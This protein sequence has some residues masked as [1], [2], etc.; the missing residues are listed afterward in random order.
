MFDRFTAKPPAY[1]E[2]MLQK[3]RSE[4]FKF[5]QDLEGM[6]N[7]FFREI[8]DLHLDAISL[9]VCSEDLPDDL[10]MSAQNR[11]KTLMAS[12][13]TAAVLQHTI[14]QTL[15]VCADYITQIDSL[16]SVTLP[17]WKVAFQ[18]GNP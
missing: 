8:T 5:V 15:L 4:L 10:Q 12:H 6:K 9:L 1:Y 17:Q 11:V 13:Q 18:S 3:T 7:T 2:A 14:E 16:L